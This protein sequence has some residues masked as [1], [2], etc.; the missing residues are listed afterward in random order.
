MKVIL[1][2]IY[3]VLLVSTQALPAGASLHAAM[4]C[5]VPDFEIAV[6]CDDEDEGG[7]SDG[8]DSVRQPLPAGR[9]GDRSTGTAA[10]WLGSE[11]P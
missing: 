9:V 4:Y 2:L 11:R 7:G 8:D 3:A 6:A 10:Q 1:T 5:W